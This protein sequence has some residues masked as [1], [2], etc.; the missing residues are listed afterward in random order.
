MTDCIV[1]YVT[2]ADQAQARR[3]GQA[4][5]TAR[6]AACANIV[7]VVQSVFRWEGE[8]QA[9]DESLCLLK[10]RK[11]CLAELV[12]LVKAEHS[13]ELPCITVLPIVDGD[14][15]Y[16]RWLAEECACQA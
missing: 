5:V 3:I 16:L 1:V 9:A 11:A 6:L 7:P 15:A 14:P 10:S 13:Y 12:A 2:C 4:A 8:V